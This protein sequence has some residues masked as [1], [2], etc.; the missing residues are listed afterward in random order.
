MLIASSLQT[1]AQGLAYDQQSATGPTSPIGN[2]F[3]NI[4]EDSPLLQSFIPTL[5]AIGFVQFEFWDIP[6]NGTNGATVSVN[7]WTGSPSISSATFLSSTTPVYMPNG[8][9]NDGLG[10]AGVSAFYF[11]T[12]IALIPGQ[13]YYLQ[14]VVLSGDDPW[15]IAIFTTTTYP[16]GAL[17]EKGFNTGGDLWFREGVVSVPEPSTL[18]LAVMGGLLVISQLLR[19]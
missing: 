6:N 13:I 8:F 14:P 12:L 1:H 9:A 15:D 16:N 19:P 2:D 4:Q 11:S 18:A 5:S 3:L 10:F 17:F 7:L